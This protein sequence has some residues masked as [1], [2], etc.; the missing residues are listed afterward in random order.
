MVAKSSKRK[1]ACHAFEKAGVEAVPEDAPQVEKEE[2][3]ENKGK[4]RR[5]RARTTEEDVR[6]C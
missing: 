5:L 1:A 3:A 4:R 2:A 6:K